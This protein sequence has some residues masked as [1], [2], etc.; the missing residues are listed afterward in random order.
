[1]PQSVGD[2]TYM[3]N[4][5]M[6]IRSALIVWGGWDGHE[7]GQVPGHFASLLEHVSFDVRTAMADLLSSIWSGGS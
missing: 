1:M 7:P 6:S 4:G 5:A 2:I 3:T